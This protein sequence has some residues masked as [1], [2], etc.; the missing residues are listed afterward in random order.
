VQS[1]HTGLI[2]GDSFIFS[3]LEGPHLH[4]IIAQ[5]G[6]RDEDHVMM[7]YISTAKAH[8]DTT[9]MIN[10]GEH[11]FVKE[12][13]WVR[14]QNIKVVQRLVLMDKISEFFGKVDNDLLQ[15]IQKGIQRSKFV[16][17]DKRELFR[18]WQLN[19]FYNQLS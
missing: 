5:E 8:R 18:E 13:S 3:G 7:V 16:A 2:V 19:E 17:K 1:S 14:Y 11:P 10:V 15:R 4:I 12:V 9:T 6:P